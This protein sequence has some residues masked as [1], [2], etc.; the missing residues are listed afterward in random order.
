[1]NEDKQWKLDERDLQQFKEQG[2]LKVSSCVPDVSA[3]SDAI[4]RDLK[5]RYDV[6]DDVHSWHGQYMNFSATAMKDLGLMPSDRMRQVLDTLH[7]GRRWTIEHENDSCGIVFAS[8]PRHGEDNAWSLSG[9]WHWDMGEI[10]NLPTYTGV[11]VCTLL[12]DASHK[13]G[14][15]LF[16]SGSHHSVAKHFHRTRGQFSDNYSSKRMRSFFH[17][18]KWFK[19]LDAGTVPKDDRVA[20]YMD[21]PSII[22]GIQL[23]VHEMIGNAGDTYFLHPL[24]VHA[25]APN[26][27]DSP[28]MMHRLLAWSSHSTD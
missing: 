11:L 17:T 21:K 5:T 13:S 14:G 18:E 20:T 1:M 2:F 28:R 12:T 22:D 24:M 3:A 27:G 8:L 23:Q 19:D 9:E 7:Y 15:T 25:G 26:G 16:I 6:N 4:W 10:Q